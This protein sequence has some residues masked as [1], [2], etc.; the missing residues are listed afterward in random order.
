VPARHALA[1]AEFGFGID[2]LDRCQLG[3]PERLGLGFRH[4][5]LFD[6]QPR[7]EHQQFAVDRV[8]AF[9]T[10][11]VADDR[12][13]TQQWDLIE[14]LGDLFLAET[15]QDHGLAVLDQQLG[16][17]LFLLGLEQDVDVDVGR[18]PAQAYGAGSVFRLSDGAVEPTGGKRV[19]IRGGVGFSEGVVRSTSLMNSRTASTFFSRSAMR[20]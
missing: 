15:A 1:L 2:R 6:D 13:I 7:D 11:G 8:F 12:Q 5:R 17:D 14:L 4:H 16:I 18:E 20:M 9:E 3:F 10:E 19:G